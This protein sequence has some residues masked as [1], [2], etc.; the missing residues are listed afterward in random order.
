MSRYAE[1]TD[2]LASKSREQIEKLLKTNGCTGLMYAEAD[3]RGAVLSFDLNGRKYRFT[4]SY[5]DANSREFTHNQRSYSPIPK[6]QQDERYQAELRRRWRV[7]YM[8]LKMHFEMIADGM[9]DAEQVLLAYTML[10]GGRTVGES[11]QE[12]IDA[13]YETGQ[14]PNLLP[15]LPLMLPGSEQK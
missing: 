7:L 9:A 13:A 5:P 10:P 12:R 6:A 2:V 14:V 1:G 15:D 11:I 3:G 4:I 8:Q